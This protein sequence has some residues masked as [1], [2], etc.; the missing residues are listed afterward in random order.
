MPD[1]SYHI[2]QALCLIE[3]YRYLVAVLD[4]LTFWPDPR[5]P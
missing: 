2:Q 4:I 3:T 5:L 1:R